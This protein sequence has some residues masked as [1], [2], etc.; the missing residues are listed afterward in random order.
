MNSDKHKPNNNAAP[1]TKLNAFVLKFIWLLMILVCIS[2][3]KPVH[4]IQSV[5]DIMEIWWRHQME[6]FSALLVLF[7]GEFTGHRWIPQRPV[8]R[9]FDVFF[10]LRLNNGWVNN[11]EAD[12]LRCHC[13]HYDVIVMNLSVK[14]W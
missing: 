4:V 2:E 11:R 3:P 10:D 1:T 9:S 8:T 6:T 7:C 13:T 5:K 14:S 12:D